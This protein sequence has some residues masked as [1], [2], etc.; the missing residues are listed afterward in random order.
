MLKLVAN[1]DTGEGSIYISI[2]YAAMLSLCMCWLFE[3]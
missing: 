3:M 2:S 1:R